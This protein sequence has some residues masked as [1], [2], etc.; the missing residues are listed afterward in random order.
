MYDPVSL[1]PRRTSC[2]S[3]T[4]RLGMF[5]IREVWAAGLE[6]KELPSR[7]TLA[8]LLMDSSR[9]KVGAWE[10]YKQDDG[11]Y[12]AIFNVKVSADCDG[13]A[14][15]AVLNAVALGTGFGS[16]TPCQWRSKGEQRQ[17]THC[18]RRSP[19]PCITAG[20]WHVQGVRR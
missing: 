17:A 13:E 12:R 5:E 19:P 20:T 18:R 14:L 16:W 3:S 4:R 10:L 6:S 11:S 7:E 8:K 15:K 9:W 1:P 2:S